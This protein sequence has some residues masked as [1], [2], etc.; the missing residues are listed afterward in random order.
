MDTRQRWCSQRTRLLDSLLANQSDRG[1]CSGPVGRRRR[2]EDSATGVDLKRAASRRKEAKEKRTTSGGE[3]QG[4]KEGG[5]GSS[6]PR[7][8]GDREKKTDRR[9]RGQADRER[10]G[11]EKKAGGKEK[12]GSGEGEEC[13]NVGA[14]APAL[15]EADGGLFPRSNGVAEFGVSSGAWRRCATSVRRWAADWERRG[16]P[17]EPGGGTGGA[18]VNALLSLGETAGDVAVRGVMKVEPRTGTATKKSRRF[19]SPSSPSLL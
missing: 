7:A 17:A 18:A 11:G 8:R 9:R 3:T 14:W 12:G 5:R 16:P 13:G 10:R 2:T 15:L 1:P 4:R 19:F 6:P